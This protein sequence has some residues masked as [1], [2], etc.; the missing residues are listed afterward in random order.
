MRLSEAITVRPRFARSVNIELDAKVTGIEGYL[1]TGRALDV[2][3]RV[4][5]GLDEPSAGRALSITGPT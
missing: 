5:R 3:R 2:V 1:P 4:T